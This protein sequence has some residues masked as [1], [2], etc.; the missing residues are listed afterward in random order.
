MNEIILDHINEHILIV[1]NLYIFQSLT[2]LKLN[3]SQIYKS[4]IKDLL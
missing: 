2:K 1:V 4:D 3:L